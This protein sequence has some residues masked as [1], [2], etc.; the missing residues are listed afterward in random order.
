VFSGQGGAGKGYQLAGF[1]TVGVDTDHRHLRRYPGETHH[2]DALEAIEKMG[3]DFDAIHASPPCTG[4]SIASSALRV[5]GR[6]YDRL[7]AVTREALEAT[8]KPYV[9]ENVYG[10][11]RELRE[12]QMLCG[13]MFGLAAVDDDGT[14]MVM[15]RHRMFETNWYWSA[16]EHLKHDPNVQVAGSYGGARKD[17]EEAR[18]VRKGGYVPGKHIQQQLLQIDWMTQR[19]MWLSIPPAYTEYIGK[20]LSLWLD[21]Q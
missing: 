17:K 13:R 2:M 12:P 5:Q 15:D 3:K 10:A 18:N 16:P 21:N 11:R 9:I 4:Y 7:I 19:G 1:E 8:G 14:P 6:V 20:Q